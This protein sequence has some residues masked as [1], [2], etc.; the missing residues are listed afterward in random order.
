MGNAPPRQRLAEYFLEVEL[1]ARKHIVVEGRSDERFFRA[2][3]QDVPDCPA[4]TITPVENLEV[5]PGDLAESGLADGNRG[6]ALAVAVRAATRGTVLRCVVDLD[7]GQN[8]DEYKCPTVVW[9]DFPAIES[10][11]VKEEVLEKANLLSFGGRLPSGKALLPALSFALREIFA[12]RLR[13]PNLAKPNYS[14]GLNKQQPKLENFNVSAAVPASVRSNVVEYPRPDAEADPRTYAYGHDVA[15][16]LLAAFANA[17][18][19]QAG[20]RTLEAVEGALR[21]AI[22][23][24]GSYV[25]E[26]LFQQ[27]RT[28]IEEGDPK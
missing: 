14:A 27:L 4:V 3:L 1:T 28:W 17:L 23:A 18:K 20:L 6:R 21:S 13:H 2:W 24:E 10:Y 25:E 12:V 9:T 11:A 22:Q 15:E 8:V 16:L 5:S 7:C 26:G 19:N